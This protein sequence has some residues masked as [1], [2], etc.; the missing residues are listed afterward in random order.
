[1]NSVLSSYFTGL[2]NMLSSVSSNIGPSF[3]EVKC[4]D[5]KKY[6]EE[7]AEYYEIDISDV[8]LEKTNYDFK[9]ML[10]NWFIEDELTYS[11]IYWIKLK[12]GEANCVYETNSKLSNLLSNSE[13]GNTIFY[14]V[15][16]IY[17]VEFKKYM[18]CFILGNNE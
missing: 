11:L 6:K 1:M 2:T 16:D 13:G 15:D 8:K 3:I 4:F 14:I 5:L 18:L 17:F 7:F 10:N 12:I 9:E